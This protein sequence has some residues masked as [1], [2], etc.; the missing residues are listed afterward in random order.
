MSQWDG[1]DK[2]GAGRTEIIESVAPSRI[3]MRLDMTRP[4]PASNHVDYT[5]EPTTLVEFR[6]QEVTGGTAITIVESGFDR[7][8]LAR[9]AEAYRMNNAGWAGQSKKLA[10]YVDEPQR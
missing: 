10:R 2:V 9:R 8:P 7:I 1:N 6:L 4:F 5:L 3:S